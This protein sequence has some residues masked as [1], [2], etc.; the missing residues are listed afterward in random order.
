MRRKNKGF[1]LVE[2]IV[3]ILLISMLGV[4]VVPQFLKTVS[5]ARKDIAKAKLA[6]LES[7]IGRFSIDC[8]RFPLQEEGLE[9][10][11]MVPEELEEK[12]RGPYVKR[13]ELVDP[14]ENPYVYIEEGEVNPGSYDLI[15]YGADGVEGG[16]DDNEDIFND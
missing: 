3:V 13:R 4:F 10:L 7:A 12:W 2:L 9:A 5:K 1:T 6:D 8:G 11:L 15:S 16:E 14:W